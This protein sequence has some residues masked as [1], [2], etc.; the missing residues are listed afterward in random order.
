MRDVFEEIFVGVVMVDSN[1]FRIFIILEMV[2]KCGLWKFVVF[3]EES[4]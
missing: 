4:L 2:F 1:C 3:K